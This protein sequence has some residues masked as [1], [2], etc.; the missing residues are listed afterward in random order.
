VRQTAGGKLIT[1]M[2]ITER[3]QGNPAYGRRYSN[4]LTL[5]VQ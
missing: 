3:H 4:E 1:A 5:L 2:R